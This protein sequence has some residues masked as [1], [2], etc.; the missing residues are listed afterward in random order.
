MAYEKWKEILEYIFVI[1]A[2][3]FE[4]L[5]VVWIDWSDI[6]YE[7]VSLAHGYIEIAM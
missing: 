5:F 2:L 3:P 1:T 4:H 7:R 6:N